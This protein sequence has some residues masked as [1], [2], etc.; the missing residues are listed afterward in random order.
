M[1][2]EQIDLFIKLQ[3]EILALNDED[4]TPSDLNSKL[5][6]ALNSNQNDDEKK[7]LILLY[8]I[9]RIQLNEKNQN[10]FV[11]YVNSNIGI[12]S[13]IPD[14]FTNDE[15]DFYV[16]I[17]DSVKNKMLKARIADV[18]WYLKY[19][20]NIKYPQYL[21]NVYLSLDVSDSDKFW[22]R[23]L[24]LRRGLYTAVQINHDISNYELNFYQIFDSHI[25]EN[26]AFLLR[27]AQIMREFT[28]NKIHSDAISK[29]LEVFAS[30]LEITKQYFLAE[31]Y[32]DE[33][34]LWST[35]E[36]KIELQVKR[37]YSYIH[38]AEEKESG[39]IAERSHYE[40][41]LKIL[42]KID[43]TERRKFISEEQED[44]LIQKLQNA[45]EKA[46]N[47]MKQTSVT[48]NVTEWIEQITSRMKNKSKAEALKE[49]AFILNFISAEDIE[50]SSGDYLK[51]SP[52]LSM[53]SHVMY[54]RD[55]RVVHQT[56]GVD[57]N[58]KLDKTNP[59]VWETMIWQY[60][61]QISLNA[62]VAVLTAL[63]T[64]NSEHHI[65]ELDLREIVRDSLVVSEIRQEIFV[66]GLL[67]GFSYD[68][69]TSLHL[70]VPQIENIVREQLH[71]RN[72]KTITL[73]PDGLEIEVGL[74]TLVEKPEFE[75]IFGEDIA[76]EIRALLCEAT[77]ANLR[78]N[79]AHGL[80]DEYEMKS[81][82]SIYFWWFCFKLIYLM[83]WNNTHQQ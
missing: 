31:Q 54:S 48:L 63:N 60:S 4:L 50:N 10:P 73:D 5:I 46:I 55:G 66:K 43:K 3:S 14:Y 57:I 32:Y 36:K 1:L 44:Q 8:E 25:Y 49:F 21:I 23:Y 15:L 42:R 35:G 78:N 61:L 41:A 58:E 7:I 16:S 51:S 47:N 70:L 9:N 76:F 13:A 29:K 27:F 39:G 59:S 6:E 38:N 53:C 72:V 28:L 33:A 12:T 22:K 34:S 67:A 52:L 30:N 24:F 71:T 2:Q 68:F 11:P 40:S 75:T 83:Y 65:T 77:G 45:G 62:Q 79:V 69:I 17:F 26:S 37:A 19:K 81:Y 18:L 74:S 64:I 56:H 80:L 20:K 82:A